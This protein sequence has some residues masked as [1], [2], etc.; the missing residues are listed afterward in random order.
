MSKFQLMHALFTQT[1]IVLMPHVGAN[2][3]RLRCYVQGIALEDGSA[4]NYNVTVYTHHNGKQTFFV[5]TVD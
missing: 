3:S 5:R 4:H 1:P 2:W